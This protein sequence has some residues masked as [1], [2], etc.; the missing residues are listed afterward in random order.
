MR[1]VGQF[2]Q[3][4]NSAEGFRR[5]FGLERLDVAGAI[6][7]ETNQLRQ[8][9]PNRRVYERLQL[10]LLAACFR[11]GF[12][13]GP[14]A[15]GHP[16]V[17]RH[18]QKWPHLLCR[19]RKWREVTWIE[20]RNLVLVIAE[21]EFGRLFQRIHCLLFVR[22]ARFSHSKAEICIGIFTRFHKSAE[23]FPAKSGSIIACASTI[24]CRKDSSAIS[25]RIRNQPLCDRCTQRFPGRLARLQR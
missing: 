11:S 18:L 19:V 5:G 15:P 20:Q 24:S 4:F 13:L 3:V 7:E 6:N 14:S 21:T 16:P 25:A 1:G 17:L 9:S 10:L 22:F 12:S 8:V 23:S 2:L